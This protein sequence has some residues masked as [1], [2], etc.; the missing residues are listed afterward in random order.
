MLKENKIDIIHSH[1][2]CTLYAALA[3][4]FAQVKGI[5][6]TDHGR[7]VPDRWGAIIE[8][9]VSSLLID[10][11]I[12]V[13][14]ELT[15]YLASKVKINRKKLMTIINGVDTERFK[16]I[17]LEQQNKL[18]KAI[19]LNNGDKIIGTVCRL[20]PI[21]NLEFLINCMP[22]ICEAIPEC[23][24]LI[25]G[26]GP[27]SEQ[28]LKHSQTLGL[29]CK[30]IFMGRKADI[31]NILPLFDIYI[32]TSLSEGTSMTILEAMACGVPVIASLVGGNPA[33]VREGKNG[34]L[35]PLD[36]TAL[37][38]SRVLELLNNTRKRSEMGK[39]ARKIIEIE[40]SFDHMLQKYS[41]LYINLASS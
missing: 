14:E 18:K 39:E 7:L 25:V 35:F 38:I 37:L 31:E 1:N 29:E 15:E 11:F 4:R 16:P 6:H 30:V 23:K 21:K 32:N 28:L 17:N 33:I 40:L 10:K 8:D 5:I 26:D 9:R 19:G 24:L 41:E 22:S 20:D 3:G 34:Y 13:S 27:D 36:R 12:G 2:G